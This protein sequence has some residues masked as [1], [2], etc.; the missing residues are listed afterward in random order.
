MRKNHIRPTLHLALVLSVLS[1]SA[2]KEPAESSNQ[3]AAAPAPAEAASTAAAPATT[4]GAPVPQELDEQARQV[5][6]K[7]S[8]LCNLERI[9]NDLLNSSTAYVPA[10]ASNIVLRG[11]MGDEASKGIPQNPVVMFKLIGTGRAWQLPI[12]QN[13][14]RDDVARDTGSATLAQSGF[15]ANANVAGLPVGTYRMLLVSDRDGS[16]YSCDNGRNLQ[17]GG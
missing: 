7:P 16:R 6:L 5:E 3:Q 8:H 17:I 13:V 10:D 4:S 9:G 14:K 11:W 15:E 12:T 2:C 1:L